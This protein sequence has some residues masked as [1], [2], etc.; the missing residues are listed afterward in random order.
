MDHVDDLISESYENLMVRGSLPKPS[1]IK[2]LS[3]LLIDNIKENY[4]K[5]QTV[6]FEISKKGK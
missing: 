3:G 4:R 5:L 6:I 1:T 2:E